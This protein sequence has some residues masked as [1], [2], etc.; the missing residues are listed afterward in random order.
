[1]EMLAAHDTYAVYGA[2]AAALILIQA[3]RHMRLRRRH[4]Q[5]ISPDAMRSLI[6]SGRMQRLLVAL[7]AL[8]GGLTIGESGRHADEDRR[9]SLALSSE[10]AVLSLPAADVETLS[11]NPEKPDSGALARV[12]LALREV[13]SRDPRLRD[14][15]LM[16]RMPNRQIVFLADAAEEHSLDYAAPGEAYPEASLELMD[17]FDRCHYFVEGPLADRYGTWVTAFS[18]VYD[19]TGHTMVAALGLDIPADVWAAGVRRNQWMALGLALVMV[20]IALQLT[21]MQQWAEFARASIASSEQRYRRLYDLQQA[22]LNSASQIIVST[23]PDGIITTFNH[24]AERMLGYAGADTI[25]RVSIATLHDPDELKARITELAL[26]TGRDPISSF[27]VLVAGARAGVPEEREWSYVRKDGSRLPVLLSV[28]RIMDETGALTGFMGVAVDITQ[29]KAAEAAVLRRDRLLRGASEAGNHLLLRSEGF[30]DAI[31]K[32]LAALGRAADVDRV[33]LFQN[34]TSAETG[35]V[36]ARQRFEWGR[37]GITLQLESATQL[38]IQGEAEYRWLEERLSHEQ[39]ISGT[40]ASMPAELRELLGGTGAR[41]RLIVPIFMGAQYWG[42]IGF[43]D[44]RAERTWEES[45]ASILITAAGAL[46]GALGRR[47]AGEA[48]QRAREREIDIGYRIQSTLLQ[49]GAPPSLS[50]LSVAA[51]ATPSDG[52]A[53]D[54]IDFFRLDNRC[55]DVVVGDVMGKG[56]PAALLGAATKNAFSRA[57]LEASQALGGRRPPRPAEV[58][59]QVNRLMVNQLIALESFVTSIYVRVDASRNQLT[60]VNCGHTRPALV[61]AAT[62]SVEFL[63]GGNMPL[64]FEAG[65]PYDERVATVEP[66]DVLVVYSD[67]VIEARSQEPTHEVFGEPGLAAVLTAAR[68]ESPSSILARI[69]TAVAVFT[70]RHTFRDDFTCVV[71]SFSACGDAAVEVAASRQF[72]SSMAMLDEARAMLRG[73]LE[74]NPLFAGFDEW[75]SQLELATVEALTNIIRHSYGATP[76]RP[77]WVEIAFGAGVCRVTLR[78]EGDLFTPGAV[79]AP[80][81]AGAALGGWGLYIME[82]CVDHVQ[83]GRDEVGRAFVQLDKQAQTLNAG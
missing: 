30:D 22:I 76:G 55:I 34:V 42:F 63:D 26:A 65:E 3:A 79:H 72:T 39:P 15:Y 48:L 7:L 67:G 20:A 81:P 19:P 5:T 73:A 36:G 82:Q 66:G 60:V 69:E 41:S 18:C 37:D 70:G 21:W 57:F 11:R 58:L 54:F 83:Y 43:D 27:E 13:R 12:T 24:A 53:G 28:T 77:L 59:D 74:R 56:V 49:A 68:S 52:I 46:G 47:E 25:G 17:V 50:S 62:G 16:G 29:R 45:E 23:N 38:F 35:R 32:A 80:D 10:L 64:G 33:Y 14:V 40:P 78:Y 2:I 61:R 6:S 31:Q 75:T 1:M 51:R 8:V 71:V 9:R 4:A 44:C